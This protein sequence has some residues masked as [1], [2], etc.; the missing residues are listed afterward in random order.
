MSNELIKRPPSEVSLTNQPT[1]LA[2]PDSLATNLEK[3][4]Q[5]ER[6][7]PPIVDMYKTLERIRETGNSRANI[8]GIASNGE[9]QIDTNFEKLGP[10]IKEYNDLV[11]NKKRYDTIVNLESYPEINEI[12]NPEQE[13]H[14]IYK[15]HDELLHFNFG[16]LKIS[17]E[18]ATTYSINDDS[19][20]RWSI[21]QLANSPSEANNPNYVFSI[22]EKNE[23]AFRVQVNPDGNV[24]ILDTNRQNIYLD[25]ETNRKT[26]KPETKVEK[27][28]SQ[29]RHVHEEIP[30]SLWKILAKLSA[31]KGFKALI[32]IYKPTESVYSHDEEDIVSKYEYVPNAPIGGPNINLKL[33]PKRPDK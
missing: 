25:A 12:T 4:E 11:D 26:N 21:R 32:G 30:I 31:W 10:I 2:T 14:K 33:D 1:N 28:V 15:E 24:K 8:Q 7:F 23:P 19:Y 22:Q 18:G 13:W 9:V 16:D 17:L 20:D 3:K 6:Q 27:I 5:R 29:T